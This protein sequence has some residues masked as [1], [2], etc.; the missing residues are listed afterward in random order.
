MTIAGIGQ[1]WVAERLPERPAHAHKGTFGR[2]LVVAGMILLASGLPVT[3]LRVT[4]F[5]DFIDFLLDSAK[6][7]PVLPV[8]MGWRVW[9]LVLAVGPAV[10]WLFNV[11]L[12]AL[13][14]KARPA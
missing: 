3:L 13:G 5:H 9:L 2:V 11:A 12:Y 8:P 1:R 6:R 4:Q 7:G 14:V 10:H